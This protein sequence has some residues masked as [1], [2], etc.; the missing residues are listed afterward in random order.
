MR[1]TNPS[2]T[3][4]LV[5]GHNVASGDWFVLDQTGTGGAAAS[6]TPCCLPKSS[7]SVV[8]HK[9]SQAS[10]VEGGVAGSVDIITRKPL[11]FKKPV[12]VAAPASARVYA[13]LPKKTD[14]QVSVLVDWK[15]E[16]STF[17]VLLQGSTRSATCA[18]TAWKSW[19]TSRSP[20]GSARRRGPPRPVAA[21]TYPT[22]IGA[23]LFT[24]ERNA[25]AACSTS[26]SS[27]T[28]T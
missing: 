9:T 20:P 18:A 16:A 28:R 25:P 17:G 26:S 13:D 7:S 27:R 12:H 4:T 1:G 24:Q 15:N 23:A 22:D 21:S 14:P 10:L 5:N 2:L 11:D 3:Q 8:V 6:A 19:A